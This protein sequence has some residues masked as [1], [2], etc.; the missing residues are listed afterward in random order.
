M[1]KIITTSGKE[2]TASNLDFHESI[3]GVVKEYF[4][5]ILTDCG[6]YVFVNHIESIE[7]VD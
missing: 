5:Y 1:I 2:Y 6:K 4:D 7:Q 3:K